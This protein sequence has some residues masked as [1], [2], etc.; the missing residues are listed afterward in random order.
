[1]DYQKNLIP[2]GTE[3]GHL[4]QPPASLKQITSEFAHIQRAAVTTDKCEKR[5]VFV[6]SSFTFLVYPLTPIPP[7][8]TTCPP[9]TSV[10][11]PTLRSPPTFLI[12]LALGQGHPFIYLPPSIWDDLWRWLCP[13]ADL[14]CRRSRSLHVQGSSHPQRNGCHNPGDAVSIN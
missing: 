14:S 5:S 7:T 9:L 4:V 1:M 12:C 10:L 11:G 6:P 2:Q 8:L 3:K 13:G